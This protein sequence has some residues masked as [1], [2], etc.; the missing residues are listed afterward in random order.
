M[1]RNGVSLVKSTLEPFLHPNIRG[2]GSFIRF[3]IHSCTAF[4]V[5]SL[6]FAFDALKNYQFGRILYLFF[7]AV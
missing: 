1:S 4:A 7:E 6:Q 5:N 3:L 2:F